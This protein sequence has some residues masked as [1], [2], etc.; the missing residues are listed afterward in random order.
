MTHAGTGV[1]RGLLVVEVPLRQ[2]Q[3]ERGG[4]RGVGTWLLNRAHGLSEL[5][6]QFLNAWRPV[7]AQPLYGLL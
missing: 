4:C 6:T 2:A 5:R 7:P 3:G 1:V